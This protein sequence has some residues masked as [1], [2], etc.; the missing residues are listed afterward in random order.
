MNQS[1]QINE[2]ATALTKAQPNIKPAKKD[3]SN[4]F[5]KSKYADFPT[6]WNACEKALNDEGLAVVQALGFLGNQLVLTT[7]LMH[8]S[9]QWISSVAP[10]LPV[11]SDPQAYG[12]AISYMKRYSLAALVGVSVEDEDDDGNC[13]SQPVAAKQTQPNGAEPLISKA[14]AD[15]LETLLEECD[16]EF[17]GNVR[18]YIASLKIASLYQLPLAKYE[19]IKVRLQNRLAKLEHEEVAV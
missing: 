17:V 1:E 4:S 10:I 6:I 5:F 11:K 3:K 12:S 7:K 8:T 18:K 14:Q 15:H 19:S 2:L 13:A 9:G 16:E